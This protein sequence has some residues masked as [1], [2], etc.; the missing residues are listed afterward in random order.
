MWVQ[1]VFLVLS[2]VG[3]I[4]AEWFK[5]WLFA[6]AKVMPADSEDVGEFFDKALEQIPW[7]QPFK[8]QLLWKVKQVVLERKEE[9]IKA[10]KE[11]GVVMITAE[12]ARAL[13]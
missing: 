12:E 4:L 11:G 7:Y 9:F 6:A 2:F 10:A 8:R 3:P 5:E 13:K 1:L